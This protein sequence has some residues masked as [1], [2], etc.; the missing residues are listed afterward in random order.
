MN[1]PLRL[2]EVRSDGGTQ[3]RAGL[4][5][6][7][8]MDYAEQ[9]ED[10]AQFPPIIVF[11]DGT[12]YWL[13]DGFHRLEARRQGGMTSITAEVRQGDRLAALRYS[14]GANDKHG[15]PRNSQDYRRAYQCGVD[16]SLCK[17]D[18][19]ESVQK[20]LKCSRRWAQSLTREAREQAKAERDRKIAELSAEG[21]TQREIAAEVGVVPQT[22]SNTLVQKRNSAEIG[23]PTPPNE[24]QEAEMNKPARVEIDPDKG[25]LYEDGSCLSA[26]VLAS[27]A[28]TAIQQI[29]KED[30][31]AIVALD[32]IRAALEKQTSIISA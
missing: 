13:A 26:W 29:S 4:D 9:M 8:V 3:S 30:P 31:N 20:L 17:P 24:T 23:Q 22:V 1:K 7:V 25:R 16:N 14:L 27:R 21:K 2:D 19:T 18:D 12:T 15:L 10:G 11:Y 28:K 32:S 5:M 6:D